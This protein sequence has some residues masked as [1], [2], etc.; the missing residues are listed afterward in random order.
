MGT[1][2]TLKHIPF[3]LVGADP[4]DDIGPGEITIM[5]RCG[6]KKGHSP[7]ISLPAGGFDGF[8]DVF[9]VFDD[10]N[11]LGEQLLNQIANHVPLVKNEL[12]LFI[13]F[14]SKFFAVELKPQLLF[15]L[16][17]GNEFGFGD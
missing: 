6:L 17:A 15:A 8:F 9:V 4:L 1:A 2:F 7:F 14:F 12:S 5:F 13:G 11:S 16:K 10:Q 3:V